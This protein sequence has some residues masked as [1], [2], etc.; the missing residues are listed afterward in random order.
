MKSL[1]LSFLLVSSAVLAAD[2]TY[3]EHAKGLYAQYRCAEINLIHSKVHNQNNLESKLEY[4]H[5]REEYEA[6]LY[7]FKINAE[8][9]SK[10][11]DIG[12]EFDEEIQEVKCGIYSKYT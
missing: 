11:E 9:K 1:I 3:I 6:Y 7:I 10:I 2:R 8:E 4:L 5:A 12:K